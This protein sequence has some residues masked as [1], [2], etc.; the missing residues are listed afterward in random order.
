MDDGSWSQE[1]DLDTRIL[2]MILKPTSSLRNTS[3][4]YEYSAE[5]SKP[6]VVE[7]VPGGAE[8][9]SE[10]T[11]GPFGIVSRFKYPITIASIDYLVM[12]THEY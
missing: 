6:L 3:N 12:N 10:A 11:K 4:L 1:E 8:T 5:C 7:A 9:S 2:G